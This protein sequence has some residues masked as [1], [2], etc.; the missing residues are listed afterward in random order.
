MPAPSW[1]ML[2]YLQNQRGITFWSLKSP[3]PCIQPGDKTR[4]EEGTSKP[5]ATRPLS[6]F[7]DICCPLKLVG[8]CLP[9]PLSYSWPI[10]MPKHTAE[11]FNK[12]L[13]K[14]MFSSE[15]VRKCVRASL[16]YSADNFQGAVAARSPLPWT[17]DIY[18]ALV[19]LA[20]FLRWE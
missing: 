2:I 1:S 9:I 10:I 20:S 3:Y 15:Q 13:N 4:V 6:L 7:Q 11:V 17:D 14:K 16:V 5:P 19:P 12:V 8:Y 18:G